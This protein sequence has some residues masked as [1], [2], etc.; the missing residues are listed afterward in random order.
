MY[1]SRFTFLYLYF[2]VQLLLFML[3]FCQITLAAGVHDSFWVHAC[4]VDKMNQILREQFVDLYSMPI[5]DNVCHQNY[6]LSTI[7]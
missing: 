7:S 6:I 5:L 3:S 2:Y 1:S 4:D